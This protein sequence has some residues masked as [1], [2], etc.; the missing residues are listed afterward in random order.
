MVSS[1]SFFLHLILL[2][3]I[4]V[5][6]FHVIFLFFRLPLIVCLCP[7]NLM[8]WDYGWVMFLLI[9]DTLWFSKGKIHAVVWGILVHSTAVSLRKSLCAGA[10]TG[11]MEQHLWL[12][13]SV[14]QI[15]RCMGHGFRPIILPQLPLDRFSFQMQMSSHSPTHSFQSAQESPAP[16]RCSVT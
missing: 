5:V 3:K 8:W 4:S 2:L 10:L 11:R 9:T 6:L 13:V 16:T 15:S 1:S 7:L 12:L 14:G